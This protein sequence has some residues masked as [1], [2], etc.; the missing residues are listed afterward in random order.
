LIDHGKRFNDA[1][2]EEDQVKL[3]RLLILCDVSVQDLAC[4]LECRRAR[5]QTASEALLDDGASAL[6]DCRVAAC[7]KGGKKRGLSSAGTASDNDS[8]HAGER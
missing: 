8:A 6:V 7:A 2:I 4:E 3:G 5:A 1:S